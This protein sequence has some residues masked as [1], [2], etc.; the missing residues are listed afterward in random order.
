MCGVLLDLYLYDVHFI[1]ITLDHSYATTYTERPG[2]LQS[3]LLSQK[4]CPDCP[5]CSV[6]IGTSAHTSVH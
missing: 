4:T 6:L 5:M 3:K 1:V 2:F